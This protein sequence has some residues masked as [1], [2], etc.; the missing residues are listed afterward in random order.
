MSL[1]LVTEVTRYPAHRTDDLVMAQWFGEAN[2][3]HVYSRN[4]KSRQLPVPRWLKRQGSIRIMRL[5]RKAAIPPTRN[6][7]LTY[8]GSTLTA[9]IC[10]ML[11]RTN[12]QRGI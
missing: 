8:S 6:L 4:T 12:V 3:K 7:S 2:L 5:P 1:K 9:V 11:Q 10:C